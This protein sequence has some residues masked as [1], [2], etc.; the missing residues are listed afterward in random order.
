MRI[1]AVALLAVAACGGK[2]G[3]VVDEP[4]DPLYPVPY[5]TT[6]ATM[7]LVP[8]TSPIGTSRPSYPPPVDTGST[9]TPPVPPTTDVHVSEGTCTTIDTDSAVPYLATTKF[10]DGQWTTELV[11][12]V[13]GLDIDRVQSLAWHDNAYWTCDGKVKRIEPTT[14]IAVAHDIDCTALAAD[15]AAIWI[16]SPRGLERWVDLDAGPVDTYAGLGT[17]RFTVR[18][19]AVRAV[20]DFDNGNGATGTRIRSISLANGAESARNLPMYGPVTSG[21]DVRPDGVMF[22]AYVRGL[23]EYDIGGTFVYQTGMAGHTHHGITCR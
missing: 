21:I 7:P 11:T 19:T 6:T 14:G 3:S 20:Y 10:G 18:G 12:S 5:P 16:E 4:Y 17:T 13:L 15:D 8:P 22:L 23:A 1:G 9:P 2:V